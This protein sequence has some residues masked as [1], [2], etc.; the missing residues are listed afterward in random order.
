M[1]AAVDER[2][3]YTKQPKEIKKLIRGLNI[4]KYVSLLMSKSVI[5]PGRLAQ[6]KPTSRKGKRGICDR[7]SMDDTERKLITGEFLIIKLT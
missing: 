1:D 5:I 6:L 2:D 7:D 4:N 3:S